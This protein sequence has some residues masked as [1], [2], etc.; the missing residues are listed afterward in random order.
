MRLLVILIGIVTLLAVGCGGN[1]ENVEATEVLL[2]ATAEATVEVTTVPGAVATTTVLVSP[3]PYGGSVPQPIVVR[4]SA[5]P[6]P[7][8][9]PTGEAVRTPT[10]NAPV[11]LSPTAISGSPQPSALVG[12]KDCGNF[13]S[14][15]EAQLFF[16]ENDGQIEDLYALDTDKDGI[17]CNA[18]GDSGYERI[19]FALFGE[20]TATP[21]ATVTATVPKRSCNDFATWQEA[22]DFFI[23]EGGPRSDPHNFDGDRDGVPCTALKYLEEN[24][25]RPTP[26]F[27]P[28]Q[29]ETD[30]WS[31]D[32]RTAE[33]NSIDWVAFR[34]SDYGY[35][36]SKPV[37]V[38]ATL[39]AQWSGEGSLGDGNSIEMDCAPR[40]GNRLDKLNPTYIERSR[41]VWLWIEPADGSEAFC[42]LAD[43]FRNWLL[44]DAPPLPKVRTFSVLP[45]GDRADPLVFTDPVNGPRLHTLP[46]LDIYS[47]EITE[48]GKTFEVIEGELECIPQN[49]PV[50]IWTREMGFEVVGREEEELLARYALLP[51]EDRRDDVG[52]AGEEFW[53][54]YDWEQKEFWRNAGWFMAIFGDPYDRDD[55]RG[56]PWNNNVTYD[57]PWASCWFVRNTADLPPPRYCLECERRE[58][59]A[60]LAGQTP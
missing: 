48:L 30:V 14:H 47:L 19:T 27:P 7:S 10:A 28:A 9:A 25:P 11:L 31:S 26:T 45:A 2:D 53:Q 56:E 40:F 52:E 54:A 21:E 33:L 43:L 39:W 24:P 16:M 35:G 57:V 34:G 12:E 60:R 59:M 41:A 22:Y 58:N 1:E 37:P 50:A 23:S 3:T 20:P 15:R 46:P 17:A 5:T 29:A 13:M 38:G 49:V 8:A 18:P 44:S 6:V 32:A 55:V 51:Y 36:A 4:P 42:V